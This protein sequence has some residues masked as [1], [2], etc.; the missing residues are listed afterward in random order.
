[1]GRRNNRREP[2]SARPLGQGLSRVEEHPDGDWVVRR[3]SGTSASAA[4][5]YRCPG[6][7]Q[8]IAPGTAHVVA[9]PAGRPDG[10]SERRHW[11]TP[12]WQARDRRTPRH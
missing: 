2:E 7:E 8:V 3:L 12:C 10:P 9:W 6:C 11:H 5:T 1:M 4:K